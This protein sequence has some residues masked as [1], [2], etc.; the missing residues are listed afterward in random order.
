[1]RSYFIGSMPERLEFYSIPVPE[2]GCWLWLAASNNRGYGVLNLR[3]KLQY[4][5]RLSY[6]T[7]VGDVP[8]GMMVCHRC[9]TPACINPAHLFAG[10]QSENMLDCVRKGRMSELIRGKMYGNSGPRL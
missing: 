2:S 7:W 9:D 1:M 3:G 5:H 10:T 8:D 6:K 4:A